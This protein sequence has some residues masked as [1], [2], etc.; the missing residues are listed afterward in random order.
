MIEKK[1]KRLKGRK[2]EKATVKINPRKIMIK[3]DVAVYRRKRPIFE[4]RKDREKHLRQSEVL[5]RKSETRKIPMS[6]KRR[7]NRK[8]RGSKSIPT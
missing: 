3:Y 2:A 8:N 7:K 4:I 6:A 5:G 1:K